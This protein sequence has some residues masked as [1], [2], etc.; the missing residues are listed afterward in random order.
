M[1]P[2]ETLASATGPDGA[3]FSLHRRDEEYVIRVNGHVLMSTRQHHSEEAMAAPLR[4]L[5]AKSPRVLIGGLG[6]GFTLRAT[7]DL[8]PASAE[9]VVAELVPPIVEWNRGPL[10]EFA[11]HPLA[12]P[13]TT[14]VVSDVAEVIRQR[15]APFDAILLDVDNGPFALSRSSNAWLYGEKGLR[16]IHQTLRPGGLL[17]VWSGAPDRA[18]EKRL[19]SAS[20]AVE[21]QTIGARAGSKGQAHTLFLGR[22][23]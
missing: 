12:D 10:A 6:L 17:V 1:K 20:F 2:W 4:E 19:H 9:V 14:I 21:T 15:H 22:R 13:R 11:R 23:N 8:L 16:T 7:L 18:F 5:Q 3:T